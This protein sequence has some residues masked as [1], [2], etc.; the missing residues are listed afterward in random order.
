MFWENDTVTLGRVHSATRD[1]GEG[2]YYVG[3]LFLL[4]NV[5]QYCKCQLTVIVP[6]YDSIAH[7]TVDPCI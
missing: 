5:P 6:F 1:P 4:N 3:T 7:P 2:M